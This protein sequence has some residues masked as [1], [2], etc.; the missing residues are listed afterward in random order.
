MKNR[1]VKKTKTGK[2]R[3]VLLIIISVLLLVWLNNTNVFYSK[4][5]DYKLLAH[6]GLAQS[7]D[8]SKVDWDTNTA[9]IIDEPEHPYLE[10]TIPSMQA[11][12]DLGADVV[13]LDV[14]LTKDKKLAV[15]HDFALEYRTNASGLVGDYTMAELKDLDIG[16]G[17][18]ADK[19]QTFPFRGKGLGLMPELAEVF[20]AFPGKELLINV[21]DGDVETY[22]VLWTDYLSRM[23]KD[24]LSL[25]TVYGDDDGIDYLREQSPDL[26]LL[27][28]RMMKKAL[29]K[30]ELLG[31]T[32]YIPKELHNMELHLPLKYAKFLWGWPNKFVKRMESVNT[33]V[34][35]VLGDG[36]WSE[37]FDTEES[38]EAIPKGYKGYIWTNRIDKVNNR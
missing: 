31:F 9:E 27:S 32:G 14:R 35:I 3:T 28:M 34:V 4:Q 33:R 25:I 2:R 13:E 37:G 22:Q 11:A 24:Q 12:F 7:Y 23:T 21:K 6:R 5:R 18:T 16:Y 38:L 36:K 29:L 10:N 1:S 19:G 20:S 8:V 17:Y 26:R 15:F 30:Y